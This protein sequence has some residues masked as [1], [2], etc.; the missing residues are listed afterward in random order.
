MP[1]S[2]KPVTRWREFY[3]L[4]DMKEFMFILDKVV[5]IQDMYAFVDSGT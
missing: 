1:W 3:R 5:I 4:N 2:F